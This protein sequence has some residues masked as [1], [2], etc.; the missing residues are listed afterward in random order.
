MAGKTLTS[1]ARLRLAIISASL[2]VTVA[3]ACSRGDAPKTE[4]APPADPPRAQAPASAPDCTR[5]ASD[6]AR[7]RCLAVDAAGLLTPG[8]GA[9][10]M[11]T[12][13]R[14]ETICVHTGPPPGV[15]DGEARVSVVAGRVVKVE[16]SDSTGCG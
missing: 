7:A 9:R 1:R 16:Q 2:G 4:A 10:A 14:G 3:A 8:L 15:M 5:E 6:E 13:R 11:E 12:V